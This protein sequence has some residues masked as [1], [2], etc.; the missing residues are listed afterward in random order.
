MSSWKECKLGDILELKYGKDH[1]ALKDG[2]IPVF[3]SGGIMRYADTSLY[4]DESI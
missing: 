3:G 2:N 1:K 4:D